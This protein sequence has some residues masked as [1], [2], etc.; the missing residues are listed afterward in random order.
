MSTKRGTFLALQITGVLVALILFRWL[1]SP[2]TAGFL[3]GTFFIVTGLFMWWTS[4]RQPRS[5]RSTVF[6]LLTLHVF[7]VA[8]PILSA[9]LM[10]QG[11]AFADIHIWGLVPG[12]QFHRLAGFVYVAL[13]VATLFEWIKERRSRETKS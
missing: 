10:N 11:V 6:W 12:P 4:F 13:V 2:Q 1:Q 5:A 8:L 3:A 7:F 9:R